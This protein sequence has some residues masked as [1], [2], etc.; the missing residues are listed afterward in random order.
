MNLPSELEAIRESVHEDARAYGLDFYE[1]IFELLDYDQLNEVAAYLG[2]PTRY[3]HWRFGMEYEKL[4]KGYTYGL[5]KIYELVINNDPCYAYLMKN[6]SLTDQKLVIAHVYGHGDFFKNNLWFGHTNHKMIDQM[7]NHATRVRRY[8]DRFGFQVVEEFLDS[9]LS[10]ENLIDQH[11]PYIRRR[12]R[13]L[14]DDTVPGDR[15]AVPKLRSKDYM[16]EYI[17][18][19]EF[20]ER[21]RKQIEEGRKRKRRVPE[22]PEKDVLLFL[23]EHAPLEDWQQDILA[24]VREESYY[25]A[26]QGMTKIMNEGWASYWHSKIMTEK[27]LSDAELIDYADHHSGTLGTRPGVI[28]PYK[29]GLEL[30]RNIEDRWNKGKFGKEYEECTDVEAKRKWDRP[31][32]QGREKIFEVRKIYNDVSFIDTFLTR[33]F[34][35]E[36]RL[37]NYGYDVSTGRWVILDRD[38]QKVKEKLLFQLTNLGDPFIYVVDSN[39]ENRGELYLYHRHDGVDLRLDYARDV[40]V[41][42][43]KIWTRPAHL[44]T[45][46]EGTRRLISFDGQEQKDRELEESLQLQF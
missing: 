24:I 11:S 45:V 15:V 42:I 20:L 10:L 17:N 29:L 27:Q 7:A 30:F 14:R 37:F 26:P 43:H 4:S 5:S 46:V 38:Y 19:S 34:C 21:Q 2:F 35:E 41:N 23:I 9:V 3:P 28:N 33:E 39:Y 31:L 25:F 6:N 36:H 13:E 1:T 12:E 18:P 32:G 22:S 8:I 44:E 16:D 40:L